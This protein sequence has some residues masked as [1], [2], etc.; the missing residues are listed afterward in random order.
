M[1]PMWPFELKLSNGKKTHWNGEDGEN[2]ARSYELTHSGIS[3]IA[4]RKPVFSCTVLGR[5]QIIG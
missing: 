4:W 2:A 5:G 3:V 1:K